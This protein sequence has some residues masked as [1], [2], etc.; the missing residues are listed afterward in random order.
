VVPVALLS[1]AST[2]LLRDLELS[3][4]TDSF[5]AVVGSADLGA[6][7]PSVQAFQA[8]ADALGV[9]L[10]RCLFVDDTAGHVEAA[11]ALG[12]RAEVFTGEDDLRV[13]LTDLNLLR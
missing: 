5:D 9:G 11:R 13:L 12:M 3:G 8:A 6:A 7:K 4:I 1:N 10:E 2:N